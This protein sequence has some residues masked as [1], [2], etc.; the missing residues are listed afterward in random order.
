[1]S[2]VLHKIYIEMVQNSKIYFS[3]FALS[4]FVAKCICQTVTVNCNTM[5]TFPKTGY[6][7]LINFPANGVYSCEYILKSAVDSYFSVDISSDMTGSGTSCTTQYIQVSPDGD[8]KYRN[9]VVYCGYRS[10]TNALRFNTI[11]NE[12]RFYIT[13]DDLKR[14]ARISLRNNPVTPTNCSCSW[15]SSM[16]IANGKNLIFDDFIV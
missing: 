3:F 16:R 13:T 12:I 9:S 15:T 10:P 1:M 6:N 5:T 2:L 11:G 8:P 14:T 7:I 4:V